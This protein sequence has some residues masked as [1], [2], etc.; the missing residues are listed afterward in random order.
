MIWWFALA[1]LT[2]LLAYSYWNTFRPVLRDVEM[3]IPNKNGLDDLK[4]VQLSDLHMERQSISPQRMHS[5][6]A[7]ANPDLIVMT[8]DYLDRYHNIDKC[9]E[10]LKEIKRVN[11]KYGIYMVFGNHDHYL[12][13]QIDEFAEAIEALGCHI[14]RNESRTIDINGTPLTIIGIDDFCLGKSDIAKSYANVPEEGIHLVLA[15]DPN[16]VLAMKEDHKAD[17]ILSGHFHGGQF[18]LIPYLHRIMGGFGELPKQDI[19]KGIHVVNGKTLYISEGLGQSGLNVRLRSR[20][21]ITVHTLRTGNQAVRTS[22]VP[23][24]ETLAPALE[25]A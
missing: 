1:T 25:T 22:K 5:L 17:Y 3:T 12:G 11:P 16:T 13:D 14:L 2:L 15:H 18:N 4:I 20:P 24:V 21:E 19:L 7:A 9:L 10:Y 8:G 6:V 23:K